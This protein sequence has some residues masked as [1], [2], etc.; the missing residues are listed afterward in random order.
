MFFIS[1]DKGLKIVAR[2]ATEKLVQVGA[3]L[4]EVK[5]TAA[6]IKFRPVARDGYVTAALPQ[7]YG[8]NKAEGYFESENAKYRAGISEQEADAF[9][10]KNK[11]YGINFVAVD[12]DG[13]VIDLVGAGTVAQRSQLHLVPSGDGVHCKLCDQQLKP[14][15]VNK[16][17]NGQKHIDLLEQ[18]ES[19]NVNAIR[20]GAWS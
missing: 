12:E 10:L 5:T 4:Q 15:G 13:V 11:N 20:G 8:R 3:Q 14:R 9:L 7:M 1:R 17:V 16:H 18:E 19:K 2:H 6:W